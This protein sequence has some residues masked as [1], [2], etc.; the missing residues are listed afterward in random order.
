VLD[1]VDQQNQSPFFQRLPTELRLAIYTFALQ[2]QNVHILLRS[3]TQIVTSY[4]H[5]SSDSSWMELSAVPC[6]KLKHIPC[7]DAED[8]HRFSCS[9]PLLAI[10]GLFRACRLLYAESVSLLYSNTSFIFNHPYNFDELCKAI[11]TNQQFTTSPL[12]FVRD[13]RIYIP[14][15]SLQHYPENIRDLYSGLKLLTEQAVTLKRFDLIVEMRR[16]NE[17][18]AQ[19][20]LWSRETNRVLKETSRIL[21]DFRGLETFNLFLP[22]SQRV[23][24]LLGENE[25]SIAQEI[26]RELV[27]L[28]K[29][30]RAMTV[31]QF[32][33]HFEA[34]YQAL[35][36]R[37][38]LREGSY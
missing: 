6:A 24:H 20:D 1:S 29:G 37:A 18:V 21:G 35:L 17:P 25:G 11:T 34:R 22:L 5:P 23:G 19:A 30:S 33:N 7:F 27:Y 2:R 3:V 15:F 4:L 12:R 28:P 14:L 38:V 10:G 13:V 32:D 8:C 36:A 16:M 9:C 26:L 31:R